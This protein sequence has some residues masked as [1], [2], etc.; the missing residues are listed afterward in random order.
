MAL[1]EKLV[2]LS[3][4]ILS[5]KLLTPIAEKF[6]A[7]TEKR[8]LLDLFNKLGIDCVIDVGA[9]K[10]QYANS[11]RN[12]GFTGLIVSFEPNP[13]VYR[14][15][16]SRFA[17][18]PQWKGVNCGLGGIEGEL[19]FNIFEDSVLSSFRSGSEKVTSK[20][21]SREKVPV[22]RLDAVL[23]SLV[24]DYSNRKIFLKSD[25]QG[26]DLEVVRGAQGIY[27]S[28]KGLQ[29]ELSVQPLYES[30]PRYIESLKF[31]ESL[32]FILMDLWLINR[33]TTGEVLEY[34]C[35]MKF[36]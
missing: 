30:T 22:R 26:F 23:P 24:P 15:L 7:A 34:D 32:G 29:S 18:D 31:Y 13:T 20:L 12:L 6:L 27:S 25:T 4:K 2:A 11:L 36:V 14:E 21:L 10:G 28:I 33:T 5:S 8:R 1:K 3:N 35:I 16:Q 9:N 17:H 19:E